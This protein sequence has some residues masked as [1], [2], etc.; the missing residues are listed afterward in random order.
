MRGR[1]SLSADLHSI[2]I[3]RGKQWLMERYQRRFQC[4][5]LLQDTDTEGSKN[6]KRILVLSWRIFGVGNDACREKIKWSRAPPAMTC[7][8]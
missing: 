5:L 1:Q 8:C 2:P 4:H 6:T 7:C 3:S